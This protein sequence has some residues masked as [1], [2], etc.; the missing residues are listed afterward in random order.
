LLSKTSV[1]V[2]LKNGWTSKKK[3]SKYSELR[4]EVMKYAMK[5]RTESKK[6]TSA[7]GMEVDA[8][9]EELMSELGKRLQGEYPEKLGWGKGYAMQQNENQG[10]NENPV[11]KTVEMMLNVIGKGGKGKGK[12]KG[13]CFNCGK[14]GH[15]A[16]NCMLPKGGYKGKGKGEGKG[17]KGGKGWSPAGFWGNMQFLAMCPPLPQLKH[18]PFPLPFPLPPFPITFSIISTVLVT[19]FSFSP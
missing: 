4:E 15:I 16:R 1:A 11:T 9:M 19:G 10:E 6:T 7:T 13:V 18:T 2:R 5:K 8:V 17:G 12:G 3:R 14:G